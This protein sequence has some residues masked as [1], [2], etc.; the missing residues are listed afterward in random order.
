MV[1]DVRIPPPPALVEGGYTGAGVAAFVAVGPVKDG[2]GCNRKYENELQE[3]YRRLSTVPDRWVEWLVEVTLRLALCVVQSKNGTTGLPK[4]GQDPD[5]GSLENTAHREWCEETGLEKSRLK[6]PADRKTT[7]LNDAVPEEFFRR[8]RRVLYYVAKCH[9]PEP[10]SADWFE[11]LQPGSLGADGIVH[12]WPVQDVDTRDSN[13]VV[14]AHWV[15]VG[16]IILGKFGISNRRRRLVQVALL[17]FLQ[18]DGGNLLGLCASLATPPLPGDLASSGGGRAR[19][20]RFHTRAP[21]AGSPLGTSGWLDS[22]LRSAGQKTLL[23]WTGQFVQLDQ[24]YRIHTRVL[25][26]GPE[27]GLRIG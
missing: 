9:G 27:R 6:L 19:P 4:G 3:F 5:D 22:A 2:V 23:R 26:G 12:T 16:H 14:R 24:A 13:P 18:R 15:R 21:L 17:E 1:A 8:K 7:A 20:G 10:R 25:R 11:A